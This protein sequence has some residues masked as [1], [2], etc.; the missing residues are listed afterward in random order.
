MNSGMEG[1]FNWRRTGFPKFY[2]GVGNGNSN[3]IAIRWQYPLSE[4]TT[5]TTNYKAAIDSQF[6]GKDDINDM[7]WLLK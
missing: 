6:A 4:R 2:A 7:L 3:R 1:Y 5:N